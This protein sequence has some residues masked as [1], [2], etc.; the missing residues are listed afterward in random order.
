MQSPPKEIVI[1]FAV[2]KYRAYYKYIVE[3]FKDFLQFP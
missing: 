3:T 2:R 1:Y